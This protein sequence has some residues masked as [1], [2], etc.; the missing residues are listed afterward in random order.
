MNTFTHR[1][2]DRDTPF[3]AQHLINGRWQGEAD[4]AFHSYA[5]AQNSVLP[6]YFPEAGFS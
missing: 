4:T 1:L 3:H 6:W 2:R 5:P